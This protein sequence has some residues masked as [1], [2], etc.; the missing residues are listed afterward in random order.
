MGQYSNK[1]LYNSYKKNNKEREVN[2]YYATPTSEVLN[3][4]ETTRLDLTD[5]K[6]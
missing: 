4:L 5:K 3:I 2:D 6:E 1:G